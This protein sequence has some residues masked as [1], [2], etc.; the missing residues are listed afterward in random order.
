MDRLHK[1]D[2]DAQ[3]ALS[4]ELKG[5]SQM[6]MTRRVPETL[7]AIISIKLSSLSDGRI[8]LE[9]SGI[10]GGLEIAGDLETLLDRIS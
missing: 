6:D 5:P 9:D 10:H 7:Q 4:G 1:L 2:I 8:L 3:R